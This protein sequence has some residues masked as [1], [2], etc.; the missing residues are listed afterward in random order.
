MTILLS[1]SSNSGVPIVHLIAFPFPSVWHKHTDNH[2]A[3]DRATIEN[4]H[5]IFTV[6]LHEYFHLK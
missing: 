6:F 2:N 5:K 3:L 4:L 1:V